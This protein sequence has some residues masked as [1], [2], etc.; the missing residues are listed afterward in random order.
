MTDAVC[1]GL[2]GHGLL[3]SAIQRP[4]LYSMDVGV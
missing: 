2:A 4:L 3:V 1:A